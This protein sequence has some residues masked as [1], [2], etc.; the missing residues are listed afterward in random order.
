MYFFVTNEP[1]ETFLEN[2]KFHLLRTSKN[3]YIK[4]IAIVEIGNMS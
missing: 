1:R 4:K 2:L 3:T